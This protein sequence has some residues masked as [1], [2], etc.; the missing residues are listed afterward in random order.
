MPKVSID[1]AD[2]TYVAGETTA[3]FSGGILT[4]TNGSQQVSLHLSGNFT[5]ATWVLSKDATGGTVVIDPPA[6]SPTNS[7]PGLDHVD[8]GTVSLVGVSVSQQHFD[9]GHFHLA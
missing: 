5:N 6:P 1:L 7:P 2:L 3:N 4:V 9:A 8:D